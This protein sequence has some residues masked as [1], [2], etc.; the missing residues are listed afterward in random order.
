M[1]NRIKILIVDDN[2]GVA[3]S[4][5]KLLE[6]LNSEVKAAYSGREAIEIINKSFKPSIAIL[7]IGMPLMDGF[8]LAE[9]LKNNNPSI[10]IIAFTGSNQQQESPY[11]ESR[12][13]T[14]SRV[15]WWRV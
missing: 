2:N 12:Q 15:S 3:N 10:K 5:K 13:K 4:L 6:L 1:A 14:I 9:V 11:F 7:D 8:Q